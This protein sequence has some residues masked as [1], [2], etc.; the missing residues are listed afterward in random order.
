MIPNVLNQEKAALLRHMDVS[1]DEIGGR[2]VP[3]VDS[4]LSVSSLEDFIPRIAEGDLEC[5]TNPVVVIH[6]EDLP[7]APLRDLKVRDRYPLGARRQI[8][9]DVV[10]LDRYLG[11]VG[12]DYPEPLPT[13]AR[14][15]VPV[16]VRKNAGPALGLLVGAL[17][18]MRL[19]L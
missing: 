10:Q 6:H 16:M 9:P 11:V 5:L 14:R 15:V 18:S 17:G 3:E 12:F 7:L 1:D 2:L 19:L 4:L 8:E 13:I